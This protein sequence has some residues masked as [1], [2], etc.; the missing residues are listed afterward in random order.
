MVEELAAI[1]GRSMAGWL[2]DPMPGIEP[3]TAQASD[4]AA[5]IG[6]AAAALAASLFARRLLQPARS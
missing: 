4:L 2:S 3:F 5:W 1:I 6:V